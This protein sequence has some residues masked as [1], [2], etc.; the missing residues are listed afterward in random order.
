MNKKYLSPT[1]LVIEFTAKEDVMYVS[2]DIAPDGDN[3][4]EL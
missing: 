4:V 1:I 3:V 2:A